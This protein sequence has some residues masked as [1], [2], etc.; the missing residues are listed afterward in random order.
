[1]NFFKKLGKT[2]TD[3]WGSTVYKVGS[4]RK[5]SK[6]NATSSTLFTAYPASQVAQFGVD[7]PTY[8][9]PRLKAGFAMTYDVNAALMRKIAIQL[10]RNF[11]CVDLGVELG[12]TCSLDSKQEKDYS[13]YIAFYVALSAFPTGILNHRTGM[14]Y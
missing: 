11:H 9:D 8:I 7:F 1:M 10:K 4:V 13:H 5:I 6:I 14:D 3:L 12:R 2:A